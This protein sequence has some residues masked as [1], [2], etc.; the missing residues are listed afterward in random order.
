LK[1]FNS[2]FGVWLGPT[3]GYKEPGAFAKRLN[4]EYGYPIKNGRVDAADHKYTKDLRDKM[5]SLTEEYDVNYWKLDGF[6]FGDFS[7]D[8][9][10]RFFDTWLDIFDDLREHEEDIFLNMTTGS[11]N[12]PWLL[13]Y[14]NSIWLNIG[15]DA[16]YVGT[17]SDR[18]QMLTYVDDKYYERFQEMESQMPLRFIYNHEPIHG[19]HV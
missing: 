7:Q 13:P 9:I 6:L 8:Y 11:N 10:T 1:H 2:K 4:K 18:D 5:M 17:G 19:I 15:S 16:G 12:S 3:G 14:V